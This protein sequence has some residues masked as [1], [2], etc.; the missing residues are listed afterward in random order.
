MGANFSDT[1]AFTMAASKGAAMLAR[2]TCFAASVQGRIAHE[3]CPYRGMQYIQAAV[4][5]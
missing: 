5:G 4:L 1:F 3:R 2:K